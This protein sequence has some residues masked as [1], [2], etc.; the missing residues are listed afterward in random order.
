MRGENFLYRNAVNEA[1]AIMSPLLGAMGY[2]QWIV[3]WSEIAY[4]LYATSLDRRIKYGG[5]KGRSAARK[6]KREAHFRRGLRRLLLWNED[7][8]NALHLPDANDR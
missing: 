7:D 4:E 2:R 1:N 3:A 6:K 8:D 5:R